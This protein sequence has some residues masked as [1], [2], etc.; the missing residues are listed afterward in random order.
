MSGAGEFFAPLQP[1]RSLFPAY[2]FHFSI[3]IGEGTFVEEENGGKALFSGVADTAQIERRDHLILMF[4]IPGSERD[5]FPH[6]FPPLPKLLPD[7]DEFYIPMLRKLPQRRALRYGGRFTHRD[8]DHFFAEFEPAE[9]K[10]LDKILTRFRISLIGCDP[11]T[12]YRAELVSKDQE[13]QQA[14]GR[15]QRL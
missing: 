9:P 10:L 2:R 5:W 6:F 11:H 12:K 7:H 15:N 1:D 8:F 14:K 3:Y 13:L 4:G